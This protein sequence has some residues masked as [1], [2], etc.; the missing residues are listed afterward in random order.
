MTEH[1]IIVFAGA[2]ILPLVVVA[3]AFWAGLK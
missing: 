1:D 3:V 2:L